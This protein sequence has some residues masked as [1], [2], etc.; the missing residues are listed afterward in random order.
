MA[1]TSGAENTDTLQETTGPQNDA[2][3]RVQVHA[4]RY[5]EDNVVHV[6]LQGLQTLARERPENPVDYL[7]MYLLQ[8]NPNKNLSVE[9]PLN[10]TS[11]SQ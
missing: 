5:L 6:L 8:K 4:R 2:E 3:E 1:S 9:V 11:A 7:A 10:K